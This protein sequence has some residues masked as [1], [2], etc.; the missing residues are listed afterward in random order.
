M[1]R[2]Q[3]KKLTN[4]GLYLWRNLVMSNIWLSIAP[5]F[6]LPKI[7]QL[8]LYM[9]YKRKYIVP[10]DDSRDNS[11]NY[12]LAI[13]YDARATTLQRIMGIGT[14]ELHWQYAEGWNTISCLLSH[15][16]S[17]SHFFQIYF[18]EKREMTVAEEA[19]IMPGLYMGDYIPQLITGE[20]IEN[21]IAQL[22]A[23]MAT[24]VEKIKALSTEELYRRIDGYD[25]ETGCN[26]AWVL[27]HVAEDEVHHRGQISIIRKLYKATNK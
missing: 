18:I 14:D 3:Q 6:H 15:I 12:L 26:L 25:K 23:S 19:A 27:Y 9:N 11:I 20:P 24:M 4:F 13:L 16:I 7:H 17:V 2:Y 1:Y 8:L 21:Y 10:L 22:D 5:R